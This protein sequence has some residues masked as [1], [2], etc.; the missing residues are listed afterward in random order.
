MMIDHLGDRM[1]GL[2]WSGEMRSSDGSRRPEC[3]SLAL[4]VLAATT[5][6][7]SSLAIAQDIQAPPAE[8]ESS[9]YTIGPSDVLQVVVWKE[10]ELSG[11]VTVRFDGMITVPLLGDQPAAGR[12]PAEIARSLEKELARY[13]EAP[14][15]TVVV[16]Q[17]KSAR[18][19]V[20]G[21]VGRSGEFPLSGPTTVL[22]ALAL[23]GGFKEYAK[24]DNIII[25][26]EDRSIVTV[27]YER[28]AEG[29]D[30]D[31]NVLLLP[32]DTIIVR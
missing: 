31:R 13:I 11:E 2:W 16:R 19:F 1:S 12:T 17:A 27:D 22:Q 15:V 21:E 5:A 29:K 23:A 20:L 32:G 24:K 25:V 6:L 30:A 26:R 7:G 8:A 28:I 9:T 14:R 3:G 10:P 4:A 18:F